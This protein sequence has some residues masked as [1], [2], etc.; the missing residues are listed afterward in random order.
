LEEKGLYL[1]E[2]QEDASSFTITKSSST[3]DPA[4]ARP[5]QASFWTQTMLQLNR[6]MTRYYRHREL[7]IT[8]MLVSALVGGLLV[9]GVFFNVG[10]ASRNISRVRLSSFLVHGFVSSFLFH[11]LIRCSSFLLCVQQTIHSQSGSIATIICTSLVITGVPNVLKMPSARQLFLRE[12]GTGHYS[13]FSYLCGHFMFEMTLTLLQ[14]TLI[15][16]PTYYMIGFQMSF[17]TLFATVLLLC[18]AT[19]SAIV[20]IGCS[21]NTKSEVLNLFPIVVIPQ[22]LFVGFLIAPIY[23][24]S[25]LAWIQYFLPS[26]YASKI[27]VSAEFGADCGSYIANKMCDYVVETNQAEPQNIPYYWATLVFLIFWYRLTALLVQYARS[28]QYY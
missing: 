17:G 5:F 23:I 9:G 8:P 2:D 18:I 22:I 12:Y 24:P 11:L 26:Y 14:V 6:E 19:T 20:L 16:V 4:T 21:V 13:V 25:C 3:R 27:L 15:V 1:T 28:S 7:F 10:E